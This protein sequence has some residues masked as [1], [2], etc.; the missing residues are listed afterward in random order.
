MT[1]YQ[2]ASLPLTAAQSGIWLAQRLQPTNSLFN[3]AEYIDIH[4]E[5]VP[6]LFESALRRTVAEAET[7]RIRILEEDGRAAQVVEERV[8]WTLPL[9]DVSHEDDPRASAESHM[10]DEMRRPVDP[11][12]GPLFA[13][14]LFKA[15]DD[16]Y[17]WYQRYHHIVMDG[18]GLSLVGRRVAE[19]YTALAAGLPCPEAPFGSLSELLED[20]A[21]YRDSD[22]FTRDRAYWMSR[23]AD[24]PAATSLA[25]RTPALPERLERRSAFLDEPT[26]AGLRATA[27]EAEVSWPAVLVAALGVYLHRMTGNRQI[28]LGLPVMARSAGRARTIPGMM[29]NVLPF[30]LDLHP[31]T[32]VAEAARLASRELHSALKHQ[33]YRAEDLRQDLELSGAE[34][35]LIGP[36]INIV[37]V[38]YDLDFAGH[39]G[40]VHNLG[41]GPVDDLSLVV[42]G[43]AAT[44]PGPSASGAHAAGGLRIDLDGNA[45]L[46]GPERLADHHRRFL[47]L[48]GHFAHTAPDTPIGRID[49]LAPQERERVLGEWN[50]TAQEVPGSSLP[51][52]F[53]AQVARTPQATAVVFEG[54]T[55][56]YAEL[57]RHANRLAHLL[58]AHGA[59]P[60]SLV[61]LSVPRSDEMI[62]A[63]LAILKSGAAYLPVDPGYPAERIAYMLDDAGPAIV[64]TADGD[65]AGGDGRVSLR[66][67]APG[68]AELLAGQPDRDPVD[69][70][71]TTPLRPQH[72]A[73]VIYTSGSTGRPKGVVVSQ[74]NAVDLA[75]WAVTDIGPRQLSRVLASTS[76]N[77]DVSVFEMFGP[78]CG[79][80]SIEVVRDLLALT[81]RPADGWSGSLISAVPSAFA[82]VLA[83][84]EV[85]TS[86]ETV[87]LAGEALSAHA[88]AAIRNAIPG[89]RIANI[90]GPTEATV[91][92]T[93]WYSDREAD[94][95]D[96]AP[97][98]GRPISNTRVYVLDSG[99]QP[100]PVGVTG[101]LYIA[102]D[103]L[104]RG[105]LRRPGLTAE[106]F[107]ADPYGGAGARMYRTGDVVRWRADGNV[108]YVGRADEQ[109]K[110]RG[111]RIELGEIEAVLARHPQVRQTAVIA[112][113][114]RA[115]VKQLVA[116]VVAEG[117]PEAGE[118]RK[119]VAAELPEY[120]VPA[121]FVTLERLPL[122]PNGKLDRRALP[123]PDFGPV[124][125]GRAPATAREEA[126]CAV[127]ADV[128]GLPGVGADD[129]FFD[130]GGDSI[131][132]IQL[133]SR[134]RAAGLVFTPRDVF[135]RPTVA[136]LAAAATDADATSTPT[137]DQG[138]G[139]VPPTP[140]VHW[141]RERGGPVEGFHQ[142]MLVRT[143]AGLT[144]EALTAG[145]Q[146]V[147][148]H[149]DALRMRLRRDGD[150]AWELETGPRGTVDAAD[151]IRRVT[152]PE[153]LRR[154]PLED[155]PLSPE[156]G[157]M[158]RAV[159]L[160]NGV[161]TPG[162]LLLVAHHLVVDGV[163][164]RIL[165]PDLAVAVEGR[166]LE[167]V[168]TSLRGWA[169]H[170][171]ALAGHPSRVDELPLWTGMF[172]GPEPLLGGRAL[173][174]ARDTAA[175]VRHLRLTLP[176]ER[177]EP[178]LT[179]VPAAFHGGV[180][181][182]LLTALGLAVADWRRRRGH[183]DASGVLVD[184]EGHGREDIVEG[185]D[186]SRTV[187][188][189]TSLHPVRLEP[190]VADWDEVW[191][192]GP[193]AGQ[194]LKRVK[195]QLRALPDNGIGY[196]LL[197]HLNP[198]T[199]RELAAL[200]TPQIGFNYL[201]RLASGTDTD[202]AVESASGGGDE[203][204]PLVHAV[205]VDALTLDTHDGAQLH[206]TWSWPDGLLSEDDV[207]DLAETWFRALDALAAHA[208]APGAGGRT[209]SDLPLV[210]LT[211]DEIDTLERSCPDLEDVL[212]P[213]PM[214][215][216]L[217]FHALFDEGGADVYTVQLFLGMAGELDERALRAAARTLLN[218]H[219]NLRSGFRHEQLGTPVQ[220]VRHE[221]ELD[222][223]TRDL[224][225]L[226]PDE[227]TAE[228]TRIAEEQR[229]RGFDPAAPPLLRF[230]LLRLADDHCRLLL[231]Y[232]HILLDG[233]SMALLAQEL[234]TLY[235]R[236]GDDTGLPHTT[237]YRDYLAWLADQDREAAEEAWRQALAGIEEPTLLAPTGTD[238][239]AQHPERV[240]LDL[241]P[242]LTTALT[243][244]ARG[245][246]LTMNTLVQGAW[247]VLLGRLT[248]AE[249]VVFGATV[250]GRPG[251]IGGV[252]SMVGLFINTLP[253]R[254][255]LRPE[256]SWERLLTRLQEQQ[257]ALM[258][259]QY[260]GLHDTQRLAGVG[261]L[262]DTLTVFENYPLDPDMLDSA[263]SGL[264]ITDAGAED[265][266]HYPLTL[267]AV[268]G[269]R[270]ALR[271]G[272]R[273]ELFAADSVR[274]IG[275]RLN[276]LLEA[277]ATAPDQPVADADILDAA[278]RERTL[279]TWNATGHD[280][281]A[282]TL[283]ELIE[284]QAARTPQATAVVF[285]GRTL[286]Y[287]ELGAR[288]NR[289][290]RLLVER[291]TGPEGY[292]ALALP[293][294]LDLIVAL[295]AVV[296]TGA[297]YVPVDPDYPAERIRYI[298]GN[299]RPAMLL[300]TA[301]VTEALPPDDDTPRLLLDT[302]D[303]RAALAGHTDRDL[304]DAER[305]APLTGRNTAYVIYTSG[306]TGKPKGV[307]V[308]HEGIVNRLLWT[309]ARYGLDASD[310]VL[311]KT[312]SGFD[313]SV[314]EFFWPLI[315]GARLVVARPEGHKDPAYLARL[316][317][318]EGVTTVHFVPSMLQV[319][320]TEPTAAHCTG[321]RRVLCSGE[322]LP[323][324]LRARFYETLDVP[325]H[326]L[327]GPTEAS[328]D[329]T[330]WEC[331][332]QDPA[333]PVPI[334]A[335]VWNTRLYVLDSRLRPVPAGVAGE[336]YLAGVQLARGYLRRP[337]LT[338]ERFVAD[339]YGGAGARM[340]RT[341]DVV[342]W[343]ADGNVE[344]VGRA[345]EQVKVRGFRIELGEI[346]AVLARH[347][348]VRQT[349][350]I[351]REDRA[352]A[353][354]LV[355]YVVADG[356]PD[357]GELRKYLGA[358]L[359][360][361]MVPAAFVT[362]ERLPL[363]PNGKLD[364]RALPAPDFGATVTGRAPATA[365]EEA[366]CAVFADVL[367]LPRIG[368]DDNF[369]DLGG[370]SIVS[371]Q[372]VSR[373][374]AAGLVFTPRDVFQHRTVAALAA[375]AGEVRAT[376]V[377]PPDH[378]IGVVPLTPIVHWLRERGG[379]VEGFHQ[380]MLVRTPAGLTLEALTAGLQTVLDHHDALRMRLRRDGDGGWEL[381]TG[382]RG[383]V[384]AADVIRRVTDPEELRGQPLRD[385]PLKP[386]AGAMVRAVWLD[387]GAH[388]PGRLLLML[389]HL[390]VDGVSWRIL[391]PDLA[392]A[393]E[394]REL[395]P[396][397]TSLRGW[398]E[399]L[400]AL[401]GHPSR[402]DELP[403]WKRQFDGRDPLVGARAL[404]PA[405]DTAATVRHLRLTLSPERTEPLLTRVP[406]AFHGGVNDVL[407]T[408]L[409]LAVADWRRR[410]GHADATE[411]LVDLEGHG[412]EDIVEG[413]DL[414][415]TVGWFT[416]L[417]PVRLEPGV[418]DWADLW[419]GGREAGQ[420][421]KRVKEQLR[422][423][424]DHGIG[425]GLLRHL[426]PDTARELATLP[427]PQIGFNYLGRLASGTD[428]DW[429]VAPEAEGLGGGADDAMPLPHALEINALT[430]DGPG[431]A[432]LGAVWSWPDGLL[433]EDDVRDLAETWFR[434]LDAL[435]AHAEGPGA[436]GHTPSDLTLVSLTQ[437][438]IDAF[439]D[440]PEPGTEWEMPK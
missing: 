143:P 10:R 350:V 90:Y 322:A 33:R 123:A 116:Y 269:P 315:T 112:R 215:E 199:A 19:L 288:A 50:A 45:E 291:G 361:Y 344:Y 31:G 7:L 430:E 250:S 25:D 206:A 27:R 220:V 366:L 24:Q 401:A 121:A 101:E 431:G 258:E 432:R 367:G 402:I 228:L 390:V 357:A 159:W 298:L 15:A 165:L 289:L 130:L 286:T 310:R 74:A 424:P 333:G 210:S 120:M 134:A 416:S 144:L 403:L 351:A 127:F 167:P 329:V 89:C 118:W 175:T 97:P 47:G 102:G 272:Y 183:A 213:S 52:L 418:E 23:F 135:Q 233:W 72:P 64:L 323:G 414:S 62:V 180:N 216:G 157:A 30:R 300:T 277:I 348:Q 232:H 79:G 314:W 75:I 252:E 341:G 55:L 241:S 158:V 117:D 163:S 22:R 198:D 391:L 128:L 58:I 353:K 151:V 419:G 87:V 335:P 95:G 57:N 140:I 113:E 349:A 386:E 176:P 84:G 129:N 387:N 247:A 295:V 356:D 290:A 249:D 383:T 188:W 114:D 136:A 346:E 32:T 412:R 227:Q 203:D 257:S 389:H 420:A 66:L 212:P 29:S 170:L 108:E 265:A 192:G 280:I 209:P 69:A 248:G 200:P 375:M 145:L 28:V 408:A 93:A 142:S 330:S 49:L 174:P 384:D 76:L 259:H 440:E 2:I 297:A 16:R 14:A 131:V 427:T 65:A 379:P 115:G 169:E 337:G 185:A 260:I 46:Y 68:T 187:G 100:V 177:T 219:P 336:L 372:L 94:T 83:H 124:A 119:H 253:V 369:F 42:D 77:F 406:A 429:A 436:G 217:L 234:F 205:D 152:D 308:P 365:R 246:G 393:V 439:E 296:K 378:G 370:D 154:D 201:G 1:G 162:R 425:Y 404:D 299:T 293:R 358:E 235:A 8:D 352:G 153:E 396:V 437:D 332:A 301:D 374:R 91:Y 204:M 342:R 395:E 54:R 282:A 103:G 168:G 160:D 287:A 415:R 433:S 229:V 270:L 334:G 126:L 70:D 240:T 63:L 318:D 56:T 278:E 428:T 264:R 397:G 107:V 261:E 325:L 435:A 39:R 313:V 331:A 306:S 239:P 224:R 421:L 304:G 207:R 35:R 274:A 377:E 394:G 36:H 413:A 267:V 82:Q 230:V 238:T 34:H 254:V 133:V 409:G 81:E 316:I 186:L 139:V 222:W 411:L 303:T 150:G 147:L 197:R 311:Q 92:A 410:R 320:L 262:F 155:R 111:F 319:F 67:D 4:G 191:E 196:G 171:T 214:Q 364:R 12:D 105:Y 281:P 21:A 85:N 195:E 13:F 51:E 88:V 275:T 182:V 347:P 371:I 172:E 73:Y 338:A 271:L 193:Q 106:R 18:L 388:A 86:A 161:N 218:R 256:E 305:L 6:T 71:R 60:E 242:E 245:L 226:T 398:A 385:R 362:L 190:G 266:T 189:F 166:E 132:S 179:R 368:A 328:V 43:R 173:D 40:Q 110:V 345:D 78:L 438:E 243:D 26:L 202:W 381:E 321:L 181:D 11:T 376:V 109:V 38:D 268:P 422:A 285:E 380:S 359:P 292:V 279:I 312:P 17:F 434:A 405:R 244:R 309:Q 148:D 407:L 184:L 400:T 98:I 156:A 307:L 178:L 284:A 53:E 9:I 164:W 37:M 96:Q 255:A 3:I 223:E 44:E 263:G 276:R 125:E 221:V 59:G 363:T 208:E 354:Q 231:T 327:Y 251:E 138:I 20:E 149:H 399:H 41:G 326:N 104:A 417:Y 426:N 392:V 339:P 122:T 423:L 355:A 5:I 324:E 360:E 237:P 99:L 48:L 373:A 141:L 283:T 211:Q 236:G 137:P 382:P 194:A 317:R 146:T 225:G 340:Y 273:P 294:S 61:A 80:G 343:R 302:A